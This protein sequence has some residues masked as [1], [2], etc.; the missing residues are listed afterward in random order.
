V[1]GLTGSVASA[2]AGRSERILLTGASGWLGKATLAMLA[3]AL[4]DDF[5][6]RVHCFGSERRDIDLGDGLVVTQL[7]LT[8]LTELP[9]APSW[10]LHLAFLTKD[11]VAGMDE[12]NYVAACRAISESVERALDKIGVTGLFVPSSGAAYRAG[13]M[14]ASSAMRLYGSMKLA[15]EILFARWAERTGRTAVIA[16]IFNVTGAYINKFDAY[17]LASFI[18]DALHDRPIVI[19]ATRPVMRSFVAT[20]EL[21]GLVFALLAADDGAITRFD[22]AG[23]AVLEM[24]ALAEMIRAIIGSSGEVSRPPVNAGPADFYAGEKAGYQALIER[25]GIRSVALPNQIVETADY[26]SGVLGLGPRI[27][28]SIGT[29]PTAC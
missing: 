16:R 18:V 10:M 28:N 6:R 11:R 5:E 19:Q 7:P 21:I 25:F 2:V 1:K 8:A 22:T 15:D 9:S 14:A 27:Y 24:G 13:D 12:A 4:G 26:I 20:R 23:E 29:G 3:E 17:A